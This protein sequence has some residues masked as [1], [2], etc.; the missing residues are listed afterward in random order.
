MINKRLQGSLL[1]KETR[2]EKGFFMKSRKKYFLLSDNKWHTKFSWVPVI[3]GDV[4]ADEEDG[5]CQLHFML[6]NPDGSTM[7]V[8][9]PS[10]FHLV[11][12]LQ[13]RHPSLG[14]DRKSA[15]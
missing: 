13:S 7:Q 10:A 1:L 8:D 3:V 12:R 11:R 15:A 2:P 4:W 6:L 5:K 9:Q 14:P